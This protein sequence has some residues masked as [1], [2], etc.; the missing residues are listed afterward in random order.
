MR[1]LILFLSVSVMHWCLLFSQ[2]TKQYTKVELKEF[3]ELK[4]FKWSISISGGVTVAGFDDKFEKALINAGYDKRIKLFTNDNIVS[5]PHSNGKFGY[6]LGLNRWLNE[7]FTLSFNFDKIKCNTSGYN[8]YKFLFFDFGITSYTPLVKYTPVEFLFFGFGPV[9]S[10]IKQNNSVEN[11][12]FNKVGLA[13]YSSIRF[14][15]NTSRM[16][17]F[18]DLKYNYIGSEI[19]GPFIDNSP[20]HLNFPENKIDFSYGFIGAGVGFRF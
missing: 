20:A 17:G 5:Y 6:S 10:K 2:N 1:T 7:N 9:Y 18:I 19:I 13:M 15:K 8:G 12:A 4:G 14:N 3:P 11:S 16:F